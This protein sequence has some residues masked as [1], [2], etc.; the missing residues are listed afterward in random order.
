MTQDSQTRLAFIID[1]SVVDVLHTDARLAAILLSNPLV[2]DVSYWY[3]EPSNANKVLNNAYYSSTKQKFKLS[4]PGPQY[5][6]NEE[7]Y[8]WEFV[9]PAT[10]IPVEDGK[11]F[12]WD[13][14]GNKWDSY[15]VEEYGTEAAITQPTSSE[16]EA[17]P[18]VKIAYIIDNTVVDVVY[19][20]E[21]LGSIFL[22]N[23]VIVDITGNNEVSIGNSYNTET[24]VFSSV[25]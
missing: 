24:G 9:R 20:D 4:Q 16:V 21:R 7:T 1:G 14:E 13:Y 2:L 5:A 17:L 10:P 11:F 19:T 8:E 22:S 25:S 18:P 3:D 15:N 12:V 23:P 6:F